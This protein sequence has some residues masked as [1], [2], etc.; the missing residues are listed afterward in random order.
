MV[1]RLWGLDNYPKDISS[2]IKW[3]DSV[4]FSTF[5]KMCF[6]AVVQ[7]TF[8]S[9]GVSRSGTFFRQGS[10]Y[11]RDL[12]TWACPADLRCIAKAS[13]GNLSSVLLPPD[14]SHFARPALF[15]WHTAKNVTRDPAPVAAEFNA[16]DY[17]T[18]V[19]H[20]SPFWKFPE[21][22]L[23]LVGVSRHYTLDEKTYPRFLHK[24]RE[25]ID[26]FAF[27]HTPDPTKVKIVER[28]RVEDEP[29]LLQTILFDEGG[30]GSQAGQGDSAGVEEGTNIQLVTEATDI[31]T[32]DVAPLQ[33]RRQRKIVVA[34]VGGSS[35][36]L[37][38]LK[39]NHGTPSGPSVAGKS[40]STVQRLLAGALL[41]VE[42]MGEP[43]PTL[44]FVTSSISA[45]PERGGEDHTES[46]TGLNLR[47]ISAPQRY[48][49]PVM[50]YVT[51]T[52]S[53]TDPAVVVKEKTAKPSLF[54][55]DSSSAGGADPNVVFFRILP[56][57][58]S[59][60]TN[61]S[62]LDDGR[63]CR[64][65]V[66]EFALPKTFASVRGTE[67]DQLFTEFNVEA[68]RQMSLS[69]EV[70]MRAEYNIKEKRRLKSVV[71]EKKE[72]L[73]VK[74]KEVEDLKAQLLLKEVEAAKAIRLR[75]EA[76][77][78]EAVEK[79]LQDK[80]KALKE[81]NTSLEKELDVKVTGLEVSAM[82]KDR[83]L[84]DLNAQLT[85]ANPHND[86]L[87]DQVHELE[88]T[89]FGLQ[90]K[91]SRYENLTERLE[92]F[93]DAQLKIVNDKFYKLYADFVEI[94]L[95]LE[96]R[97]YP[98]L[99]T[100]ISGGRWLLTHGM[101]LAITKCLYS[102]EYLSSFGAAIDVAAYN[103]SA[104]ADYIFALQHLQNVN[105]SLLA[106]L[107]FNKDASVDNTGADGNAD[108]FPNVDD[109]ELN[110]P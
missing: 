52:T 41:N 17:A 49:I 13:S 45:T 91:L 18:F 105:F 29:L 2:L 76:S 104:E 55:A 34:D 59:F 26:L 44:P 65:M 43:I 73:K 54:A 8:G 39:E 75:A 95:H 89:S 40:R 14:R 77:K 51:T 33:P 16:Q 62:R 80:V 99:L 64:E 106:D 10:T 47:T 100:T 68:A 46:V 61:G 78:F 101:E 38:K 72:L 98:H 42:V 35:H 84:T 28:E 90:E 93:Q 1:T 11:N 53:T 6:A 82:G 57:V 27:I 81:R 79:S 12:R 85:F 66:D 67:H 5:G 87:V 37:K 70:R 7:T 88:V 97:F 96:E 9:F 22:F 83:E 32:K 30:S 50:T 31:V 110:I 103:P 107:R 20:P 74:E 19:A 21:E 15:L 71:D 25:D 3:G 36:P 108:P 92:E 63:I 48:S 24:N 58:T 56:E 94:A 102:P 23:C 109:A 60:V 69:A 86:S 4:P